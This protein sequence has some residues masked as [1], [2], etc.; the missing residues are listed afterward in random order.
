[1]K[2]Q[3]KIALIIGGPLLVL[4]VLGIVIAMSGRGETTAQGEESVEDSGTDIAEDGE[5]IMQPDRDIPVVPIVDAKPEDKDRDG[6]TDARELELGTD[7]RVS[8]SDSDYLFD[9]DEVDI[10]GT[11]PLD[12]DSDGDGFRDGLEVANGYNPLGDGELQN[13]E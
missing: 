8:D 5:S 11:D 12:P 3:V 6:L 13:Q 9:G 1:M 4:L 10:W 2:K 7:D